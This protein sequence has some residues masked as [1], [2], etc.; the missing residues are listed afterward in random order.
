M[1]LSVNE[2]PENPRPWT[3]E[4]LL[5]KLLKV[6][7]IFPTVLIVILSNYR[8]NCRN[9]PRNNTIVQ[10]N[11]TIIVRSTNR[12]VEKEGRCLN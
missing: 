7:V 6:S 4:S 10:G 8:I 5:T 1:H 2:F 12:P 9:G 11:G 3:D